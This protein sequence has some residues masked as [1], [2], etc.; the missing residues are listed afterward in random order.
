[1]SIAWCMTC[2]CILNLG[3]WRLKKK[4]RIK[5]ILEF[6]CSFWAYTAFSKLGDEDEVPT[7]N[8]GFKPHRLYEE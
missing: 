8:Q 1:M 3:R 7:A 2:S 5:K 6:L 4:R